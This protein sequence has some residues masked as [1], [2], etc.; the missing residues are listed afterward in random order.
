MEVEISRLLKEYGLN[1]NEIKVYLSLV[2][3]NQPTAYRLA[4]ETKIHRSTCYDILERLVQK[5]FV[6]KVERQ[7]KFVYSANEI[8]KILATIR[9]KETLLNNIM[10]K[11]QYLENK[12]KTN[13]K[14]VENP[15]AQNEFDVKIIELLKQGKI[16]FLYMM[17]SGP[18]P[19]RPGQMLLI[20]RILNEVKKLKLQ[21]KL[22]YKGIWDKKFRGGDYVR[23]FKNLGENRFL[24]GVPTLTTTIIFDEHVAFLYTTD[25]AGL[26]EINNSKIS[27]EM[28]AYFG[29]MWEQAKL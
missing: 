5:G 1:E 29:F 27:K 2:V 20:E 7:N 6:S 19:E 18:V 9:D 13:V 11:L 4:K 25:T 15:H 8:S 14:F 16:S 12:Q 21:R 24:E 17:G 23:L 22:D 3:N 28:K 10:P 26:I